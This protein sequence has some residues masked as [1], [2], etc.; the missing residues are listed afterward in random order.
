MGTLLQSAQPNTV[1]T[2]RQRAADHCHAHTIILA[3]DADMVGSFL[4]TLAWF[5]RASWAT[6]HMPTGTNVAA[7]ELEHNYRNGTDIL[8][9][10]LC[11]KCI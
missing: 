9:C 8:V 4:R 2:R 7:V 6:L 5:F 11:K 1:S 3:A 10:D